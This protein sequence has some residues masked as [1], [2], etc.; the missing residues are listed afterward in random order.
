LWIFKPHY[1]TVLTRTNYSYQ[2]TVFGKKIVSHPE[3]INVR[4]DQPLI[5]TFDHYTLRHVSPRRSAIKIKRSDRGKCTALSRFYKN[6]MQGN[7]GAKMPVRARRRHCPALRIVQLVARARARAIT[8]L[9]ISSLVISERSAPFPFGPCLL[10]LLYRARHAGHMHG[11]HVHSPRPFRR[12]RSAR[13]VYLM[14]E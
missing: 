12:R 14:H 4:S 1:E 9:S 2:R 8:S 6:A 3:S 5:L 7:N 10:V 11:I 13:Q